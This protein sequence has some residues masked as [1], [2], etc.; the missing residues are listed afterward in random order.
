VN[1]TAPLSILEHLFGSRLRARALG[2]LFSHPDERYF[3][4]QLAAILGE[5]STNLSRELARLADLGIVTSYREG[6][7]KYFQVAPASP[8]Y[9]ELR[10]LVLK[11]IGVG[12]LLREALQP[13]GGRI[14]TAFVY[15]SFASGREKAASDVDLMVIGDVSLREL[16]ETLSPV[17]NRLGREVNPTA[18]PPS[19]FHE[20]MSRGHHFLKDVVQGPKIFLIGSSDEL[21]RLAAIRVADGAS[22]LGGRDPRSV[23]PR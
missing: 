11:T 5:D 20:K 6:Q 2:W 16:V 1:S 10:G 9:P 23:G 12:E 8:L 13:L 4:R 15:G 14:V 21:E 3:V 18:Y 22:T 7:Q 17:Q 19:E